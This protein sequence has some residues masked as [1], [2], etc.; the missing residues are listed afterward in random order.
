MS[1]AFLITTYNRKE[2]CQR[3]VDSLRGKGDIIIAHDGTDYEIDGANN[4]NPH[5]HF[6]KQ[7]Y[8]KLVNML[9]RNRGV[10][11]YYFMLP[12]DFMPTENMVEDAIAIWMSIKDPRKICLSLSETRVGIACWTGFKPL[13]F[14]TFIKTQWVDGCFMCEDRFFAELGRI[15]EI[16]LNWDARPKM[17]SGVGAYISKYFHQRRFSLCQVKQP[18]VIIQEEH[19]KS[20]IHPI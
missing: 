11:D 4:L 3:L 7:G 18:L 19:Y 16:K 9:F 17:S 5:I 20:Q 6:G 10:Y 1:I 8:W 12:D 15:S 13:E 14:D 2:S